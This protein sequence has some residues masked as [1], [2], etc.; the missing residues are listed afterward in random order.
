ME[1]AIKPYSC[2]SFLHPGLDALLGLVR[3]ENLSHDAIKKLTLRFPTSG[4]HCVDANPLKSHCAQYIL[5]VAVVNRGLAVADIF[6]DRRIGDANVAALARKVEVVADDELEKLFPDFYATIIE[7]ET[8]DG[9]RFERRND[10]A[11][12]YPEVPLESAELDAKF[13]AL[14]GTVASPERV[15]KLRTAIFALAGAATIDEYA[16]LLRAKVGT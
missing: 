16:S 10:I 13:T 2:V 7:V 5:P 11:R 1:L 15:K 9:R 3:D 8:K 14:A 4:V 12:G 6:I